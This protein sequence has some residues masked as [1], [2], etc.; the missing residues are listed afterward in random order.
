VSIVQFNRWV[1]Y[2]ELERAR[3]GVP[4]LVLKGVRNEAHFQEVCVRGGRGC[5]IVPDS[6]GELL[7]GK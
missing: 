7:S 4:C 3:K 6:Q 5:M 2:L 1:S